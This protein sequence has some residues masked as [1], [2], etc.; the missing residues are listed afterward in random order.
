MYSLGKQINKK[1]AT[2]VELAIM[3]VIL[4]IGITSVLSVMIATGYFAKDT[5]DTIQATNLAREWIEGTINWRNTNWIRFSSD[6][7][8]CFRV[9]DYDSTCIGWWTPS[10]LV[11]SWSYI[12]YEKNGAWYLSSWTTLQSDWS[13]WLAY[14]N[15]Y[16]VYIGTDWFFT[17]TGITHSIPCTNTKRTDCLTQ[18]TREIYLGV[19]N[20]GSINVSSIVRW[21]WQR[22]REVKLD[23]IITNWR[24]KF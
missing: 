4:S 11:S 5:E 3:M 18:F 22:N 12:L 17:Q 24:S 20:T 14:K 10:V 7:T 16:K 2:L 1:W 9:K 13:N 8:N 15:T 23:S 6:K 21:Q 19:A